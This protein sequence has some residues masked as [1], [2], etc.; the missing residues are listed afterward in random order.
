MSRLDF[1]GRLFLISVLL[2]IAFG[3]ISG[4]ILESRLHALLSQQ[5]LDR[6]TQ[7]ALLGA[8]LVQMTPVAQDQASL[9]ALAGRIAAASQSRA[10]IIDRSGKV[11]ADSHVPSAELSQVENHADRPEVRQV[12]EEGL[13]VGTHS[14]TSATI[15]EE[16]IYLAVA[17]E[18]PNGDSGVIRLAETTEQARSEVLRLRTLMLVAGLVGLAAAAFMSLL[19][20]QLVTRELRQLVVEA[21]RLVQDEDMDPNAQ[22]GDVIHGLSG[23]VNRLGSALQETLSSLARERDRFEGVL[24][25][26]NN[27]VLALSRR[28]RIKVW[29]ASAVELLDLPPDGLRNQHLKDHVS[30]EVL[31]DLVAQAREG[32][33]GAGEFSITPSSESDETLAATPR[34]LYAVVSPLR[35]QPGRTGR[36]CV[37]VV[38]DVTELRRLETMRRDFIANVSHELRTPVS[39]VRASA[40][41]LEDGALDDPEVAPAFVAS[42]LRNAERQAALIDDLLSLSRIEAG[43][44]ELELEP[45]CL[46]EAALRVVEDMAIKAQEHGHTIEVDIPEGIEAMADFGSL[47]QVLTNYLANAVAY[48]PNGSTIT[49]SAERRSSRTVRIEVKDDGPGVEPAHRARLFERFYRVDTGRSRDTGGTGLGLA[50]VKHLAEAMNGRAGFRPNHP[51]GSIFWLDLP[52]VEPGVMLAEGDDPTTDSLPR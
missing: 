29:N 1:R 30:N 42:I 19:A 49:L 32:K 14:R 13:P 25:S 9:E 40:E 34:H 23:S 4:S 12:L 7:E 10:T 44:M 24:N 22:P 41:A 50:I 16:L 5:R 8:E 18:R 45:L 28:G 51:K 6:M 52:A 36:G 26:M 15:G 47:D 37:V 35:E 11:L 31:M 17:Y 20:A 48:V 21:R 2:V 39:V 46:Q 27:G 43:R 38:R 33:E 3:L